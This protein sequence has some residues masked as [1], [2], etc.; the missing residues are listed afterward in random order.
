[1]LDCC[2]LVA[3][4]LE[5][6]RIV[7]CIVLCIVFIVFIFMYFSREM[8]VT[9]VSTA[10]LSLLREIWS[11][12]RTPLDVGVAQRQF[13]LSTVPGAEHHLDGKAR[14]ER[15]VASLTVTAPP[16]TKA[17]S[18]HRASVLLGLDFVCNVIEGIVVFYCEFR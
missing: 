6:G 13:N 1:M 7:F 16:Q 18:R 14:F 3:A 10:E 17:R 15:N 2:D 9:V 4:E 8:T 12:C 5:E 11:R